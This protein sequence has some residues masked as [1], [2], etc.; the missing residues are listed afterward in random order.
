[1]PYKSKAQMRWM[2]ANRPDLAAE[3]DKETK[4]AKGLP[5]KSKKSGSKSGKKSA[6]KGSSSK[7][8]KK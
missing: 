7:K 2:H 1:M 8:G 5:E 3:F 6:A 4:N